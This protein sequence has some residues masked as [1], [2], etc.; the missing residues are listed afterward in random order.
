MSDMT[1]QQAVQALVKNGWSE[2]RIAR[3][4]G[5]SQPTVHRIKRGHDGAAYK[6]VKSLLALAAAV[7]AGEESSHAA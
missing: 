7:G 3:E 4:I 2:A 6:T 1:P 5:T